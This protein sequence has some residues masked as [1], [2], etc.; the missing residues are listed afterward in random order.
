MAER[1]GVGTAVALAGCSNAIAASV[2]NPIDVVKIRLQMQ[3]EGVR[4]GGGGGGVL[5]M[6]RG[7]LGTEGY[8]GLYRGLS[9]SLCREMSYSGI[10]M[11][12][13]EPTRRRLATALGVDPAHTPLHLKVLAGAL[14]GSSGSMLCNPLDLVKV[15]MQAVQ[16]ARAA[17]DSVP[18]ALAH[19]Y[20]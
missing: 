16:S 4:A 1:H 3:G 15:R 11:G 13:Y 6:F 5:G 12:M 20:R 8:R 17:Y 2:T 10:R 18:S 14:T 7:V 19:I 9:A